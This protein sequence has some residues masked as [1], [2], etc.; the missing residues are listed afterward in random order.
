MGLESSL[1]LRKTLKAE[2]GRPQLGWSELEPGYRKCP[3]YG[4]VCIFLTIF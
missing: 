1:E 2:V 3:V 4:D